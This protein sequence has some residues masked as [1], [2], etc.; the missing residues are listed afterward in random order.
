MAGN[1]REWC[2]N[3]SGERRFTLGEA[4]DSGSHYFSTLIP[5]S[6]FDRSSG[7]GFRCMKLSGENDTLAADLDAPL[8]PLP[9]SQLQPP[10]PFSDAEWQDWLTWLAYP[11]IPLTARTD[12]VDDKPPSWRL[13]KVS[14]TAAY[15]NERMQAYLFLPKNGSRPPF[16]TILFWPGAGVFAYKDSDNGRSLPNARYFH[17][18]VK[19][20]RAVLY[21]ILKDTFERGTGAAFEFA[22]VDV[23]FATKTALHVMRAQDISRSIDYLKSR[24]D[25]AGDRIGCLGYSWGGMMGS[26]PCAHERERIKAGI[27]IGG[28]MKFPVI[29]GWAKRVTIPMLMLSGQF[30]YMGHERTQVPLFQTFA[31]PAK[32]KRHVVYPTDHDLSGFE[33]EIITES[34]R[35]F[36]T[37]LGPVRR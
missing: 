28:S 23:D 26:L 18:L 36:D 15:G 19:D 35:W 6:P 37:Y 20:G 21:P 17:H 4:F 29:A 24:S 33:K 12:L 1:A 7:N 22:K 32:D 30:D 14:F 11:E 31:T 27:L 3:A 10:E 13:E 5:R 9:A 16:Q 8:D 2:F 34:L 25:I